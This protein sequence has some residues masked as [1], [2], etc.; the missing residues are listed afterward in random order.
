MPRR[1]FSP[2][3]D[4]NYD[5]QSLEQNWYQTWEARGHFAPGHVGTGHAGA[6]CI[7]IPPGR[8]LNGSQVLQSSIRNVG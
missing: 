4:K 5:P 6:Y 1:T 3:L 8:W 2:M 7:M